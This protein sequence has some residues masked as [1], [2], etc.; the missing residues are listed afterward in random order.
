MPDFDDFEANEGPD[1][2]VVDEGPDDV[3]SESTSV[4]ESVAAEVVQESPPVAVVEEVP[5]E[6]VQEDAP[7]TLSAADLRALESG[8]AV[9][10]AINAAKKVD[11]GLVSSMFA[12]D[13][14]VVISNTI[15]RALSEEDEGRRLGCATTLIYQ[16][17]AHTNMASVSASV[18]NMCT[19]AGND[20]EI[21]AVLLEAL[22]TCEDPEDV[23]L[24]YD[25]LSVRE[26]NILGR[27]SLTGDDLRLAVRCLSQVYKELS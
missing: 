18:L 20:S 25:D 27:L 2:I 24:S 10:K 11:L 21:R 1:E 22:S 26:V 15:K 16:I 13:N 8:A 14:L 4:E 7:K 6:P 9:A 12:S 19:A 5:E 17:Q 3:L 23:D